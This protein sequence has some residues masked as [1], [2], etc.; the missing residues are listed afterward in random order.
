[1]PAIAHEGC[2]DTVK[3]SAQK[4]DWGGG[5]EQNCRTGESNLRR[6]RAGP[7]LYQLSHI[8]TP[9]SKQDQLSGLC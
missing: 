9:A 4:I 8:P 7:M 5:E 3:E 1:M 2:T 6:R